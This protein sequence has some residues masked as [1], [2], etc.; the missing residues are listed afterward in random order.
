MAV[1]D[2]G[3]RS[4]AHQPG[5]GA[6]A[7]PRPSTFVL[8]QVMAVTGVIFV[9]FVFVH[10]IGNLKVYF[11]AESLDSYAT[12]LRR[13][14]YP[15]IPHQ[16]VLWAL[17]VVLSVSLLAHM[18]AAITLWLRGRRARGP[19]RRRRPA[20]FSARTAS[21]MLPGGLA[22]AVFVVVHILDLT[23]GAG[24]AASGHQHADP[25]GTVHAYANLVAS[26]SRPWMAV[27]YV[28]IMLVVAF[29]IEHGVR[30]LMQDFGATGRR[31][32]KIW[33]VVGGA[34]AL[35][36]VLG[37]ALIPVLVLVGVIS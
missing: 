22:I 11:G 18:W 10:M 32:R 35:A 1:V 9:G 2:A 23:L 36:V 5:A 3:K 30:T 34:L 4:G 25:D 37:N 21:W 13:V 20:T 8:K 16:G 27:F 31:L 17:R 14:G 24:V 15:L 29:H 7:R 12:W 6:A 19:H 33:A 28:V 26:F